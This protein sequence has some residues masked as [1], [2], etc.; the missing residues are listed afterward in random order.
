MP[1]NFLCFLCYYMIGGK[2][3]QEV[4][5]V[6]SEV[7]L[8]FSPSHSENGTIHPGD[9]SQLH[10]CPDYSHPYMAPCE[11]LSVLR[12]HNSWN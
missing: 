7:C 10:R 11:V 4:F 8:Q 12:C 1:T 6:P 3:K 9:L 2:D 5:G